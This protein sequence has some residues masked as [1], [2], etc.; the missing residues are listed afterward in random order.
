MQGCHLISD[1]KEKIKYTNNTII[2]TNADY[3]II[4][5]LRCTAPAKILASANYFILSSAQVPIFNIYIEIFFSAI[6][7]AFPKICGLPAHKA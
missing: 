7:G 3:T 6:K 5:G 4:P 1:K 2:N